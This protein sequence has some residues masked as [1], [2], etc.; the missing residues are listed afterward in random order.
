MDNL[1]VEGGNAKAKNGAE[2]SKISLK[3]F[4]PEQ[5]TAF[6]QGLLNLVRAINQ[7]YTKFAKE[8]LF[9]SEDAIDSLKIFSGSGFEFFKRSREEYAPVK[10]KMGDIDVQIDEKKRDKVREF[11]E[12]NE[13]KKFNGF[14]YLGTQFGGDFYNIFKA[15]KEFQPAATNIQMD[16]EFIEY[17]E[18]GMPNEFDVF[19]KNSDWEDLSQG[20]KGLA[21]NNL[22]PVIYKVIYGTPGVVFQNKKDE[23]SKAFKD[24]EVPTKTYGF[25]GSRQKY[26]PVLDA[27][28]KQVMYNGK[29]AYR[30]K[31]VKETPLNRSLPSIFEEIFGVQPSKKALQMMY[32]FT[33]MLKLMNKYLTK[34]QIQKI[35]QKYSEDLYKQVDDPAVADT[36]CA[37]FKKECPFIH[38][39]N[40]KFTLD[41]YYKKQILGE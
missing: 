13:G 39:V 9:P 24:E 12:A 4:T 2:A 22:I 26:Q 36:I 15:P 19:A 41:L 5:Y 38:D 29:P 7:A 35:Y 20:I 1:I 6:K 40:E 21:K 28:G 33:G 27:E 31:A 37:K 25:K 14:T 10:P 17:D 30:E 32:S 23:P 11:L 18:N 8:P 34:Q 16:F 3:D